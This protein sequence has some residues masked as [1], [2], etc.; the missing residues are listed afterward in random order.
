MP[1]FKFDFLLKISNKLKNADV[2]KLLN[3]HRN[4]LDLK[5][6]DAIARAQTPAPMSAED[7]DLR[8]QVNLKGMEL[9]DFFE[10][11]SNSRPSSNE[12]HRN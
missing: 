9:S 3:K 1:K 11:I 8:E 5:V 12:I 4:E 6:E 2:E 7:Q 10:V